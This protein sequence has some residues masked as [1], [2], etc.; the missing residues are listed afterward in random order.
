[1]SNRERGVLILTDPNASRSVSIGTC[2]CCH[3]SQVFRLHDEH[4]NKLAPDKI[5]GYCMRCMEP[6]CP[7]C[8]THG[9]CTP[10]EEKLLASERR[11]AERRAIEAWG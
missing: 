2:M 1:M 10:F 7:A 11:D 3:C 6:T 9:R 4:G 5:G 8:A